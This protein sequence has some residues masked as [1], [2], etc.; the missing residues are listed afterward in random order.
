LYFAFVYWDFGIFSEKWTIQECVDYAIK[1]NLQIQAQA[2]NKD[3][4]TKNL[5]MAKKEY[6]PSVSGTINN[7]A[8]F[9][10]T[11]VGTSSIRNDSYYNGA[12]VGA[13]ML[14]FNNGRLEKNIRK[15]GLMWKRVCRTSKPSKITSHCKLHS[16]T[17]T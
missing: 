12:N 9:G 10:Q 15:Q 5:E 3:V 13:S 1:N 11:L 7:N 4:Q 8:N 17:L 2:Y 16:N 14:V 6:L